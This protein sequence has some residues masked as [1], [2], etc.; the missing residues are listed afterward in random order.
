VLCLAKRG[1][2]LLHPLVNSP[3][4]FPLY[5]TAK[6]QIQSAFQVKSGSI[7]KNFA[8]LQQLREN[9]E[10]CR[11]C[12][13]LCKAIERYSPPDASDD[14]ICSLSWEVDG[15][16][17]E[18]GSFVNSTRRIR[19]SW[20]ESGESNSNNENHEAFLV[21]V[22]PRDPL[23][24]NSD[25]MTKS[26]HESHFLGRELGDQKENQALLRS[27]LDMCVKE[28]TEACVDTHT[29]EEKFMELISETFF[30][31]I[32]VLDMQLKALPVKKGKPARYVALSYVWGRRRHDEPPYVTTRENIMTHIL[33]GGLETAWDKLPR[34]I[35][36]AIL[37][38]SRLGERYLWVD[39]LCI[40]Q[41]SDSSWRLNAQSM[42]LVYGHAYFTICAADGDASAGLQAV[43]SILQPAHPT[44]FS[45]GTMTDLG[46]IRSDVVEDPKSSQSMSADYAP[47]VR[48][49]VRRSLEAVVNDSGWNKR[50]WT[51][52]ERV[53]SRRCLIF[54][55]GGVYFQCR[56]TTISQDIYA[57][58]KGLGW[59]L[60]QTSSPLQTL[61]ELQHRPFWFYIK[62]ANMY[63]G[64][65][66]TK[67][68]DILAA[69]EGISQL[70]DRYT[71]AP[72]L[73]GLPT[74]HFDLALL[75]SPTAA[76]SRRRH[77]VTP[78][79]RGKCTQD[80]MGNCIC[81][82][83][84][85]AFGGTEFPSWSWSGWMGGPVHY[86]SK[87][88]EGCLG[89][90]MHWLVF[91][92]WIQWYIR[93]EKGHL[94]PLSEIAI[95]S[96]NKKKKKKNSSAE[97]S[98]EE[99]FPDGDDLNEI[100]WMGYPGDFFE[101]RNG[102]DTSLLL[103]GSNNT[104]RFASEPWPRRTSAV[105]S[106]YRITQ[107]TK[108]SGIRIERREASVERV[109]NA[110]YLER[111]SGTQYYGKR[112]SWTGSHA[113][114]A[115]QRTWVN[116]TISYL[117]NS[118]R[119]IRPD[120][121]SSESEATPTPKKRSK[122]VLEISH[123]VKARPSSDSYT[124]PYDSGLEDDSDSQN[125]VQAKRKMS[126]STYKDK[127]GRQISVTIPKKF[128]RF[129]AILPDNPFGVIRQKKTSESLSEV[130]YG[131]ILQFF[132]WRTELHATSRKTTNQSSL[133]SSNGLCMFDI[134]DDG[135]DWCGSI[136]LPK[137]WIGE[138]EGS[139]FPFIA[140]SDAKS[141]TEEECPV[142]TFYIPK[143]RDDSEWDL[144][145]VFLLERNTERGLWE[146]AGLGKVFKPAFRNGDWAEIKL[147]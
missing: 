30:G 94:R 125:E 112:Q 47:D 34:T 141:F 3:L 35:Q 43:K 105:I 98:D 52:Q 14:V 65:N 26:M 49:M 54:A 5:S 90:P 4:N 88:L 87:M 130:Q 139:V 24:P 8:R 103:E 75:W 50:A 106:R 84:E 20:S 32:D 58:S 71:K 64:R 31:V 97:W 76:L 145:F 40:V 60:D 124:Y 119:F 96:S 23:R 99:K 122:R 17:V 59:S 86:E 123:K 81:G 1:S 62:Y 57:G 15:R 44:A 73:F 133:K 134:V 131:P 79:S 92:T 82:S 6:K 121:S 72:S 129:Q 29:G 116:P 36:D 89:S 13:L 126:R 136:L 110:N 120:S 41:D 10:S 108:N 115:L 37:L 63:T 46:M 93:D 61:K 74:S 100:R 142:W 117:K 55:E 12:E 107:P 53:L 127:Y 147:G 111:N 39:S 28:H 77:T 7:R 144:Y 11:F 78:D 19:L 83:E 85:D 102:S 70:F 33:H 18:L 66:L 138:R 146:R 101:R 38:V 51:F 25:A 69:F 113:L 132:T 80:E 143:E 42:H 104:E 68:R 128:P 95:G 118:T 2:Q 109:S 140:I 48:I 27:W 22:A 16:K 9:R 135:R 45:I 137:D 21:F 67:P 56:S 91:H 114:A